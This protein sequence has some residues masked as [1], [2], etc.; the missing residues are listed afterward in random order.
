[1]PGLTGLELQ[2]AL[3]QRLPR[4]PLLFLT[5]HGSIQDAVKAIQSGAADYL[6]KPFDG[7]EL[8]DKVRAVLA[9]TGEEKAGR[10][11]LAKSPPAVSAL[12]EGSAWQTSSP[13][14]CELMERV[15]RV[16]ERDVNVL[17]LGESGTGKERIA[18]RIHSMSLRRDHPLVV[19][20]CGSTPNTLLESELFGHVKG[21]F[22]HAVRDKKGLIE[23]A[24]KGTL[25]LDEIGNISAEMQTRLLRFL[26]NRKIRRIGDTREIAVDCRVIAATNANLAQGVAAGTFREDLYYR[27]RVVTLHVPPLRERKEDIALLARSFAKAFCEAQRMEEVQ[28]L[29]ETLDVML[30][31]AWPG[32][33]RELKNAVEAGVVLCR[34]G[35]LTPQDL[36]QIL[37]IASPA[38]AVE[39]KTS[40]KALSLDESEKQAIIR[41]LE[42]S[43]WVQKDAAPLLGVSRRALNYKIQKYGIEIPS[44]R[45][46]AK[47]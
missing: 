33:V 38:A 10:K 22:T 5:A 14:M 13:K 28:I 43:N 36:S 31:Y 4:L 9:R 45:K 30:E 46:A 21:A 8:L 17:I 32:N 39:Q 24:S 15:A 23:E 26:E 40:N 29:P 35:R 19:V 16:A 41:A 12:A 1:M 20:D 44:K 7:L 42:R 37:Q 11:A 27:L 3:E 6:T 34:G 18:E 2:A 25:F 47:A